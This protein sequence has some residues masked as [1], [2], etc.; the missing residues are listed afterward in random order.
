MEAL[1]FVRFISRLNRPN[2]GRLRMSEILA[3]TKDLGAVKARI[4]A[5]IR[6]KSFESL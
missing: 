3:Y 6:T 5:E 1:C 4:L 2:M